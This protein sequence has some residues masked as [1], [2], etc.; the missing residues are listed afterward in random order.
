M[1]LSILLIIILCSE[2]SYGHLTNLT[3][4]INFYDCSLH[5]SYRH[6]IIREFLSVSSHVIF[7]SCLICCI[8]LL[9]MPVKG[10]IIIAKRTFKKCR[11]NHGLVSRLIFKRDLERAR[12]VYLQ[13]HHSNI[14]M[15]GG[16]I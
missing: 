10:F 13:M 16:A 7:T 6:K 4:S 9:H 2:C 12:I 8:I 14:Q 1:Q 15:Y 3:F 11:N 5:S